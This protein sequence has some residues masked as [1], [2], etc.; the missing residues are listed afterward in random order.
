MG[1]IRCD[2]IGFAGFDS[3]RQET[4]SCQFM[5]D[6]G[7]AVIVDAAPVHWENYWHCQPCSPSVPAVASTGRWGS[8]TT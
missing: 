8:S 6:G 3:G 1:Q 5:P 7:E 2:L 4:W